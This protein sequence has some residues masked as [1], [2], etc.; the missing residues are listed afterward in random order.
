LAIVYERLAD[1]MLPGMTVRMRRPRFLTALAVGAFICGEYGPDTVAA[2][3]MTPPYLVFEWW[4][5]DALVRASELLRDSSQIPGFRKVSAARDAG[6]PIDATS[7]L[8]TASVFGFTGIFRR[9]ARRAQVITE[10]HLLDESG[11]RLVQLWEQEQR[12]EGFYRGEA[13]PGATLRVALTKAVAEGL[14]E[15]RTSSRPPHFAQLIA[16]HLDPSRP[17]RR[18]GRLLRELIDTRAG[19]ADEVQF[20]TDNLVQHREPLEFEQEAS[21]LRA[22]RPSAPNRLATTWASIDAYESVCRPLTDTF[23]WLR[24][25][26]SVNAQHGLVVDHFS[27]RAPADELIRRLQEGIGRANQDEVLAEIWP[28]RAEALAP[29]REALNPRALFRAIIDHHRKVQRAKPPDGKRP[30]IEEASRGRVFVRADYR[31]DAPP[32]ENLPYVHEY[33]LPTLSRFLADFGAFQ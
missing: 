26:A 17:D 15:G 7:Y 16:R 25:L 13:G 4:V 30:W 2:D 5:I 29:L 3:G 1:R 10:H 6:R 21:L 23:N 9:L 12:L 32:P 31:L 22:L 19:H 20:I 11:H 24:Y 33:R 8:K 18:E 28:E 27:Q 14:R